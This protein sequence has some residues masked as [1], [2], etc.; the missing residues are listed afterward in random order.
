VRGEA[1]HVPCLAGCGG[2]MPAPTDE[3]ALCGDAPFF[4][5][6]VAQLECGH[7]FHAACVRARLAARWPTEH[8]SFA[9]LSCALCRAR[10]A[11]A[12]HAAFADALAPLAAKEKELHAKVLLRLRM[13]KM[14]RA[15][16]VTVAGGKFFNDELGFG[17]DRY[18][19]YECYTCKKPFFGGLRHCGPARGEI[20]P[21]EL[22]CAACVPGAG[23]GVCSKHGEDFMA[24]KCVF[25]CSPSVFVCGGTHNCDSCHNR[26]GEMCS[27]RTEGR[28][29]A[30][31]AAP[32]GHSL[33]AGT[34]CPLGGNHPPPGEE[35]SMGCSACREEA[36]AM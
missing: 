14:D 22:I 11:P 23:G 5:G 36:L 17:L 15:P 26:F 1:A 30:C 28:L 34:P 31:P 20:D 27:M 13:E 12:D 25:C 18:A 9:F 19:Y 8:M 6:P 4:A 10:L 3:C 24:W 16:E 33:A 21:K 7:V 2:P 35:F 29:P 32:Q